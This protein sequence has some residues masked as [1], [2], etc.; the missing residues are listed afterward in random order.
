M[1]SYIFYNF[2]QK[3]DLSD[4]DVVDSDFSID[5][6][7]DPVSDN[8]DE[9]PKRRKNVNTRS[10]K[11]PVA[12]PKKPVSPKKKSPVKV[13]KSEHMERSRGSRST[14]TVFDSNKKSLSL[15]KTT[16]A[17]SAETQHRLKERTEA[18][19]KKPKVVKVDDYIPTQEE[20][21]EEAAETEKE[22]LKCLGKY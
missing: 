13:V 11:E 15:R 9:A 18:E 3:H 22:N 6:N 5:E 19:R 1:S 4:D 7:D 17:K 10:Y 21:L 16:A 2:S 8:E 20:L 14:F 12:K